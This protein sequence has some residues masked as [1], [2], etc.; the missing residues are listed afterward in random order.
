MNRQSR[1]TLHW[2]CL[3]ENQAQNPNNLLIVKHFIVVAS[4]VLISSQVTDNARLDSSGFDWVRFCLPPPFP[5]S[6]RANKSWERGHL[7]RSS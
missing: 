1:G 4:F 5:D 2:T 7:A 3:I 6:E